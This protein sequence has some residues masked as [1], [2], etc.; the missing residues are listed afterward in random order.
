LARELFVEL[1]ARP[2]AAK[3]LPHGDGLRQQRRPV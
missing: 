1:L 2:P 3:E